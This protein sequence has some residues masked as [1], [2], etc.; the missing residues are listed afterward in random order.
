MKVSFREPSLIDFNFY[1]NTCPGNIFPYQQ[2]PSWNCTNFERPLKGAIFNRCHMPFVH[3]HNIKDVI[4]PILTKLF[5]PNIFWG[6][7]LFDPKE[8]WTQFFRTKILVHQICLDPNI[9]GSKIAF[10]QFFK[11]VTVSLHVIQNT[12]HLTTVVRSYTICLSD[13]LF[14]SWKDYY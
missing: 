9:F 12:P 13:Y 14:F 6:L 2:Y 3:G 8:I 11:N 1:C 7:N 5:G 4:N 10:T